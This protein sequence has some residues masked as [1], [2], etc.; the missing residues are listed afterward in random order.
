[1][2]LVSKRK[3]RAAQPE[4]NRRPSASQ[5][6]EFTSRHSDLASG[7]RVNNIYPA[8]WL[9]GIRVSL[10]RMDR[11]ER[12]DQLA[13]CSAGRYLTFD[14]ADVTGCSAALYATDTRQP[15]QLDSL[16]AGRLS[17]PTPPHYACV[18]VCVYYDGMCGAVGR[19]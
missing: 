5:L 2:T 3:S 7:R 11:M 19:A 15:A 9:H 18:C 14:P 17:S 1:M 10:Q 4:S 16:R 6:N 8:H 13:R 12:T